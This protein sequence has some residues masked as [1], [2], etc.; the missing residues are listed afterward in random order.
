MFLIVAK[1]KG[2]RDWN[3][4]DMYRQGI[5]GYRNQR[6]NRL[7][8]R[9]L[10]RRKLI[11]LRRELANPRRGGSTTSLRNL[12]PEPEWR[13]YCDSFSALLKIC[14][15]KMF[16]CFLCRFSYTLGGNG[17]WNVSTSC[18]RI[19]VLLH[20]VSDSQDEIKIQLRYIYII[21]NRSW[22]HSRGSRRNQMRNLTRL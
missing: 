16:R 21:L 19:Y 3:F 7:C 11:Q 10:R 4:G 2:F 22:K 14:W 6:G 8:V 13:R 5:C 20:L 17:L 9:L 1:F 15:N 18:S 12:K